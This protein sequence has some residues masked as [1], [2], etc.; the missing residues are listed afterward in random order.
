MITISTKMATEL[1]KH[2][3]ES[4]AEWARRLRETLQ[5]QIAQPDWHTTLI[6][7][8]TFYL[9]K[10][11]AKNY[12]SGDNLTALR[13]ALLSPREAAAFGALLKQGPI[14][15][16]CKRRLMNSEMATV[17]GQD[18]V[19]TNCAPPKTVGCK[20][21][22]HQ[23]GINLNAKLERAH[24]D[25]YHCKMK[26]A[27][28]KAKAEAPAEG[29]QPGDAQP[30]FNVQGIAEAGLAGQWA[31]IPRQPDIR[32]RMRPVRFRMERNQDG[33]MNIAPVPEPP[34]NEARWVRLEELGG[35]D[36]D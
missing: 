26:A 23:I 36:E 19:C 7:Q 12:L 29:P 8:I 1:V 21:C 33:Q 27:A 25:C 18:L 16:G 22:G 2:L 32:R 5:E 35:A 13:Q 28:E 31:G 3:E 10:T 14:C 30:A 6:G 15:I 11:N 24:R 20:G 4:T 17:N 9:T 34:Q